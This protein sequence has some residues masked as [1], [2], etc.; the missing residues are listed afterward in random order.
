MSDAATAAKELAR[1]RKE[2]PDA[3]ARCS[4]LSAPS[5]SFNT[6]RFEE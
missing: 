3:F 1:L 6:Y 5:V 4:R 2:F